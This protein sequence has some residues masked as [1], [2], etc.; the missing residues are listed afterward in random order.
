LKHLRNVSSRKATI[1]ESQGEKQQIFKKQK[2]PYK[3]VYQ[4]Q[5]RRST[6]GELEAEA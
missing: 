6:T 5:M 1:N 3:I 4:I 2:F